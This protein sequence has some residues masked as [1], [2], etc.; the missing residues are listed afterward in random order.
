MGVVA[1]VV[2][3]CSIVVAFSWTQSDVDPI[4]IAFSITMLISEIALLW[5]VP[6]W[7]IST[8]E[9]SSPDALEMR[10]KV[11][12]QTQLLLCVTAFPLY[13]LLCTACSRMVPKGPHF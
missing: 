8:L 10:A 7:A 12:W 13:L 4:V 2:S 9:K 6:V 11:F 5:G 3:A 1:L